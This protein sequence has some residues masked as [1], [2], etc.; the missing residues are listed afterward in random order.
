[1]QFSHMATVKGKIE[2]QLANFVIDSGSGIS[3]ISI[4][5]MKQI[6][7]LPDKQLIPCQLDQ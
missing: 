6:P 5:L 4:D 1:M 3:V 2:N 7:Q